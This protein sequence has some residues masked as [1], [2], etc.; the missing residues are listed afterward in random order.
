MELSD[1]IV[2]YVSMN[3]NEQEL[4]MIGVFIFI[5]KKLKFYV[6]RIR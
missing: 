5:F 3:S 4:Y 1:H 2:C 6:T